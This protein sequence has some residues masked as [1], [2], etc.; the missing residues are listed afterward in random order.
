MIL[1]GHHARRIACVCG[2][3][4]TSEERIAILVK[5]CGVTNEVYKVKSVHLKEFINGPTAFIQWLERQDSLE[6]KKIRDHLLTGPFV[7]AMERRAATRG[8]SMKKFTRKRP[9]L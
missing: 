7:E 6:V 2:I 8:R 9:S 1:P 3:K 5:F 4:V